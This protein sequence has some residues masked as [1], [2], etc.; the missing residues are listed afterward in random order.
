MI[1]IAI[2]ALV[3]F[4]TICSCVLICGMIRP[5]AVICVGKER[6][7]GKIILTWGLIIF[8]SIS[9]IDYLQTKYNISYNTKDEPQ[10]QIKNDSPVAVRSQNWKYAIINAY[11]IADTYATKNNPES[12]FACDKND[13]DLARQ[14]A[15]EYKG[16]HLLLIKCKHGKNLSFAVLLPNFDINKPVIEDDCDNPNQWKVLY[17]KLNG[18]KY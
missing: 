1:D 5:K 17:G 2:K 6:T 9:A 13:W 18:I 3:V 15:G 8:I 7:R 14:R 4:V 11:L 16:G 10:T 12:I